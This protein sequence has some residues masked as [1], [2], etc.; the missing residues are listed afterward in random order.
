MQ[1]PAYT[2]DYDAPADPGVDGAGGSGNSNGMS[3]GGG[4]YNATEG[5]V[6]VEALTNALQFYKFSTQALSVLL[7]LSI[8]AHVFAYLSAK[9][10][11]AGGG[12]RGSGGNDGTSGRVGTL[13]SPPGVPVDMAPP[14]MTQHTPHGRQGPGTGPAYPASH[15]RKGGAPSGPDGAAANSV[16]NLSHGDRGAG[17]AAPLAG[18]LPDRDWQKRLGAMKFSIES[19]DDDDDSNDDKGGSPHGGGRGGG[20]R[21]RGNGDVETVE[22]YSKYA[23]QPRGG[24]GGGSQQGSPH[25]GANGN[26]SVELSSAAASSSSSTAKAGK[27]KKRFSPQQLGLSL[28]GAGRGNAGGRDARYSQIGGA[29]DDDDNDDDYCEEDIE[30][31]GDGEVNPFH[32]RRGK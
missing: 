27:D 1:A 11:G 13:A 8:M 4:V 24:G 31:D 25:R 20:G 7:A 6:N 26:G 30:G 28:P 29:S 3:F 10:R 9:Q 5:A 32:R 16:F 17:G 2:D 15:V 21:G 23:P 12:S 22:L 19:D 14:H 18:K